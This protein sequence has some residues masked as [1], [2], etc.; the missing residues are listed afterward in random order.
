MK[1]DIEIIANSPKVLEAALEGIWQWTKR[2]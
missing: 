2:S 1:V